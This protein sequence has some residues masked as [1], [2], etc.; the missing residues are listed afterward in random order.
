VSPKRNLKVRVYKNVVCSRK[1]VIDTEE[2]METNG[3]SLTHRTSCRYVT[4]W[5]KIMSGLLQ[6]MGSSSFS[7]LKI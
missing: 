7:L 3:L 2:F 4:Y 1:L 6:E 5:F